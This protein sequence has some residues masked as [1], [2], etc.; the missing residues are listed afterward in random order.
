MPLPKKR[1][2]EHQHQE[3]QEH[4]KHQKHQKHQEHQEHQKHQEHQEQQVCGQVRGQQVCGQEIPVSVKSIEKL[5]SQNF[6]ILS[7]LDT[8]ISAQQLIDDR[9]KKIEGS[10][11]ESSSEEVIKT[12]VVEVVRNLLKVSIYPSQ[13]EFR[14]EMEKV[15]KSS[16]PELHKSSTRVQYFTKKIYINYSSRSTDPSKI[17]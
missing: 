11:D 10:S 7:K 13:N 15:L 8:L 14:E 5:I 9:L 16:F 6:K 2:V 3:H 1:K 4:Q 17:V 12:T